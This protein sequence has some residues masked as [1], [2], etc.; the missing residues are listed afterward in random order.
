[1]TLLKCIQI[2][3][4]KEHLLRRINSIFYL[5][6]LCYGKLAFCQDTLT[7]K[8]MV[9]LYMGINLCNTTSEDLNIYV[10][11][12]TL[13]QLDIN[14][15]AIEITKAVDK[16]TFYLSP[17][18]GRYMINNY[19]NEHISLRWLAEA[20][21][22]RRIRDNQIITLGVFSSPFTPE[23][24]KSTE[25]AFYSRALAPEY[26]PYYLTGMKWRIQCSQSLTFTP[27][28]VN[29]WQHISDRKPSLAWSSLVEY[30]K[31][32]FAWNWT[33]FF[34]QEQ[35]LSGEQEWRIFN[36]INS[37]ISLPNKWLIQSCAYVGNQKGDE[38]WKTWW[39]ANAG[40]KG[41]YHKKGAMGVRGE[42][43]SD[44]DAVFLPTTKTFI[45]AVTTYVDFKISENLR[46]RSEIKRLSFSKLENEKWLALV[47][48]SLT[49]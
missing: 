39:Q 46:L 7:V 23:N 43:F 4:V 49:F 3:M 12:N 36:E 34:G 5:L 48:I 29:G 31:N 42:I 41:N 14:Y 28:L 9:D 32:N 2:I 22:Q 38:G 37:T 40:I 44:K 11:S 21:W 27:M 8:G 33:N 17:A 20:Y 13:N 15:A 47:N 16:N 18:F 10:S 35:G 24:W 1:M 26:V 45:S 6:F 30:K 25:Q 19:R